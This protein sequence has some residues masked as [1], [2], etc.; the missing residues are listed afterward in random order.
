MGRVA[1]GPP[2][3]T[4]VA[5]AA[6][7]GGMVRVLWVSDADVPQPT[8]SSEHSVRMDTA[9]I[10]PA[11]GTDL[12]DTATSCHGPGR[13]RATVDVRGGARCAGVSLEHV[14]GRL[15]PRRRHVA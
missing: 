8:P 4:V 3:V 7:G 14:A 9:S 13:R 12:N 6:A 5:D 11:A 1:D 10:R 2:T 15:R